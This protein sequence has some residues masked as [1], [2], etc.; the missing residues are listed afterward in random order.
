MNEEPSSY[1]AQ[2]T[3]TELRL[4]AHQLIDAISRKSSAKKLL[5][6]LMP[7]LKIYAGYKSGR[8]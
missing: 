2:N 1:H 4:E 8:R 5:S 3:V 6:G 7:L